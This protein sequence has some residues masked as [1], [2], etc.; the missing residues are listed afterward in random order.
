VRDGAILRA[1]KQEALY[2]VVNTAREH[3]RFRYLHMSPRKLDEDKVLSGRLVNEGEVIAEIGNYSKREGGTSY[4]LHFDIQ[5]P[6]RNGWVFVNPYMT[7]V[8]AYERLLG[9]RGERT[10]DPTLVA[11][12]GAAATLGTAA[13]IEPQKARKSRVAKKK[14][15]KTK[16]TA[17]KQK[18]KKDRVAGR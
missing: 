15:A 14:A 6:T 1:P 7:L 9:A 17:H 16:R 13:R 18:R 12:V 11:T 8:A 3:L 2:L 10:S 5:V 4:H